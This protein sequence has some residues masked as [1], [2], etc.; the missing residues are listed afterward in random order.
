[1]LF[2]SG[3]APEIMPAR[4][5]SLAGSIPTSQLL[6]RPGGYYTDD[7]PDEPMGAQMD[8]LIEPVPH[9]EPLNDQANQAYVVF[10]RSYKPMTALGSYRR[11]GSASWYGRKFHGQRT[12]SG[13]VYNMFALTAAHPTLPIPSYARVHNLQNG[14]S[15]VVRINDRGPYVRGRALDLSEAAARRLGMR[16]RGVARVTVAVL[17]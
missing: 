3:L 11:Q 13:E 6:R 14:R 16:E 12:S 5:S 8:A 7:A 2:R 15:V 17:P 4:E 1:M 10:G 9:I